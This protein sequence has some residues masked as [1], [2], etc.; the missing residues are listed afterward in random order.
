MYLWERPHIHMPI[1]ASSIVAIVILPSS[2]TVGIMYDPENW[3]RGSEHPEIGGLA[4]VPHVLT[5]MVTRRPW[6][7]RRRISCSKIR[8]LRS[9]WIWG[10]AFA[11]HRR[12]QSTKL[13]ASTF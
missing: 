7:A 10:A 13:L 3:F 8:G 6:D 9:V 11:V 5:K 4:K 1:S 2:C 12:T